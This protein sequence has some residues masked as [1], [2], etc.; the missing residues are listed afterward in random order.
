MYLQF[1]PIW[2]LNKLENICLTIGLTIFIRITIY[3]VIYKYTFYN[4]IMVEFS[5]SLMN[6]TNL[7]PFEENGALLRV[8]SVETQKCE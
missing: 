8:M 6:Y 1:I 7:F 3:I 5:K 4:T 2:L